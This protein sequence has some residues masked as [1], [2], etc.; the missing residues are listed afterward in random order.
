MTGLKGLMVNFLSINN[1]FYSQFS[2]NFC[3]TRSAMS[4]EI[5]RIEICTLPSPTYRDRRDPKNHNRDR[6]SRET[7]RTMTDFISIRLTAIHQ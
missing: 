3:E 2:P 1:R 7:T 4:V 6:W 5:Y